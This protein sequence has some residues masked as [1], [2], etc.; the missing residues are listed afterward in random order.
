MRR[1]NLESTQP[2]MV[3]AKAVLG[4]NNQVLLKGGTEIK[5]QY[6]DYLRK[7]GVSSIYIRDNR[8]ADIEINDVVS[9]ETRN[10]ARQLVKNILRDIKSNGPG[11][12]FINTE[13]EIVETVAKL[14]DE[15]LSNK[16]VLIQL[17]DIR[18]S[19]DYMFAHS[20]NCSVL[21]GVVA[22]KMGCDRTT[23]KQLATGALLHDIGMVAIPEQILTKPGELTKDEIA[24]VKKHPLYGY[25][26]F[27]KS[28]IYHGLA[29]AIIAQHHEKCNGQ[30]YPYGLKRDDINPMAQVVGIANV[31]DALTSDRPYR[32]AFHPH[33]AVE[34]I[35]A[36]GNDLFDVEVLQSFL[37]VVAAYPLGYHV[38]LSNGESG[39]VVGNNP[40]FTLHPIVRILY[41][42]ED[43]APHPSPYDIDLSKSL[44][45]VIARVIE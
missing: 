2:G 9:D 32:K 44:N 11:K 33:E 41:T 24:T 37:A 27:K 26:I 4:G 14:I 6:I 36:W 19:A 5:P 28:K 8:I 18:T 45:L 38:M 1:I 13:K 25:E 15:L 17:A 16:D 31:Y 43:L 22:T 42:G 12:K 30:G 40:G 7:L 10:E 35:I 20:V 39:L 23:L 3:V 21:A 34:M 29:G